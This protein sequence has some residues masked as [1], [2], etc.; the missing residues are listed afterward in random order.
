MEILGNQ[1]QRDF[2]ARISQTENIPHAFLFTGIDKIGK[3]KIAMEFGKRICCRE[4]SA[5]GKCDVCISI[6][7]G[8]FPDLMIISDN[9][10]NIEKIRDFQEFLSLKPY[11]G[12]KKIGIIENAHLMN[13]DTQNA[14][15]KTL[16]EPTDNSVIFLITN[17]P[18]MLL[19]TVKSR[20]F[21]INFSPVSKEEIEDYLVSMG[22]SLEEAKEISVLSSGRPGRAVELFENMDKKEFFLKNIEEIK[23]ICRSDFKERFNY[24]KE[25]VED[26]E[27]MGERMDIMERLF[28]RIL[29]LKLYKLNGEGFEDYDL[30]KIKDVLKKIQETKYNIGNTNA[31][32]KLLLENL[33]IN[34]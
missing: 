16:E 17:F 20:L 28:R 4:R 23:K 32:K 30:K 6:E 7:R 27:N 26:S 18:D 12:T 31:S 11:F 33:I 19:K 1:K 2:L 22:A 14:I 29:L 34:I 13:R 24:V 8:V 3:K 10:I 15:L 21:R 5:C 9:E 25:I